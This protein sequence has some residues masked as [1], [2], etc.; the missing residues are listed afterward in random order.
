[1]RPG[2]AATTP[3]WVAG[4]GERRR[5]LRLPRLAAPPALDDRGQLEAPSPPL[6]DV[7]HA[8]GHRSPVTMRP[9]AIAIVAGH[10]QTPGRAP[11]PPGAAGHRDALWLAFRAGRNAGSRY[12]NAGRCGA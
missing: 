10:S 5:L 7:N 6:L 8:H 11:L 3:S 2:G 4:E 1:M 9:I 12:G